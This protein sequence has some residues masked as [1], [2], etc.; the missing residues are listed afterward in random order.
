MPEVNFGWSGQRSL[1]LRVSTHFQFAKRH[2]A[3]LEKSLSLPQ[4]ED[5]LLIP[6]K[7]V[8]LVSLT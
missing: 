7:I 4:D 1:K 8:M 5:S 3:S 2:Y 6:S